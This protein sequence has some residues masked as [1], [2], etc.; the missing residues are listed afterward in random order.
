MSGLPILN[1]RNTVNAERQWRLARDEMQLV[2]RHRV[3]NTVNAERQ[4]RHLKRLLHSS[5]Y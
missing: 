3:R 2:T 4:W 1:V 5:Q